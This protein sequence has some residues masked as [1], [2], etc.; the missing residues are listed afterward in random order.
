[1]ILEVNGKFEVLHEVK[2][3]IVER[4]FGLG[5]RMMEVTELVPVFRHS[6]F[7]TREQAIELS[8]KQGWIFHE[9][10]IEVTDEEMS[11]MKAAR[12]G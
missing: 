4:A 9:E 6:P 3:Q 2:F 8:K 10:E 5:R 12:N 11:L 1:M 7:D